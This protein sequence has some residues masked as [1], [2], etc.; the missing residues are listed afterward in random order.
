MQ[1]QPQPPQQQPAQRRGSPELCLGELFRCF[2][3]YNA[4]SNPQ[5]CPCC[6]KLCCLSCIKRWIANRPQCPHCRAT[7][8]ASQLVPCRF[9]SELHTELEK[10]LP[11]PKEKEELCPSHPNMVLNYF[12]NT[13]ARCIC[14]DCAMFDGTH[15]D[16]SFEKL[17]VVYER[18]CETIRGQATSL[19][20][21]LAEL[22]RLLE[23]A[24]SEMHAITTMKDE[25]NNELLRTVEAMQKRLLEKHSLCISDLLGQ[26]A[27]VK[28]QVDLL[29]SMHD[30]LTRHL[31]SAPK[32]TLIGKTAEL[33]EM[34]SQVHA[35]PTSAYR[36]V[37]PAFPFVSEVVP[38]WSSATFSVP[39]FSRIRGD[40]EQVAYSTP[41]NV[42]SVTWRLKVYPS[43][44][45]T[46]RG[47]FLSVFLEMVRGSNK[48]TRYQYRIQMVNHLSPQRI[49]QREFISEFQAGECWG[50]NRFY[51][52]DALQ[53]EGFVNQEDRLQL[54]FQVRPLSYQQQCVDMAQYISQ[55]EHTAARTTAQL[56]R[57][58]ALQPAAP[59]PVTT[60][61]AASPV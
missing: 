2:I 54:A 33:C 22:S 49:V 6:S 41:L 12:C 9:I 39:D 42:Y 45:G 40:H 34:L 13:C 48:S 43:G 32:A 14:S 16:H 21:R 38:E 20:E 27:V 44:N 17:S 10:L 57:M 8:V 29:E 35:R 46:A 53:R 23:H 59:A 26:K 7:L 5:I 15:R 58:L 56:Q 3:C 30:E 11:K 25:R 36:I 50:Y 51:Q 24:D 28:E 47:L 60:A 19:R 55:L 1:S 31:S 4:L 37:S 18:H 61:A 52:L